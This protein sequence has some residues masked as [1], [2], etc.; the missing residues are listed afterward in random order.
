MVEFGREMREFLRSHC[1]EGDLRI[2]S[3]DGEITR[4]HTFFLVGNLPQLSPLL[5]I[6]ET[7]LDRGGETT[8]F[9]IPGESRGVQ[10][11]FSGE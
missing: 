3:G 5:Q 9:I 1:P 6:C 11:V 8:T 2:V 10:S 7:C 4:A